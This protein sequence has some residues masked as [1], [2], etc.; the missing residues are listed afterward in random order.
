MSSI[1]YILDGNVQLMHG[2]GDTIPTPPE[3]ARNVR[4]ISTEEAESTVSGLPRNRRRNIDR[5]RDLQV[6][7]GISYDQ[8]SGKD[9]IQVSLKK[10]WD[11]IAILGIAVRAS[12]LVTQGETRPV[13]KYRGD[14]D[15]T[16]TLTPQEAIAFATTV[17]EHVEAQY[18]ASW[19]AKDGL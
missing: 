19:M 4:V 11:F 9:P 17:F 14:G 12:L 1:K 16:H 10:P 8:G 13:L 6:R 5:L 7:R 3:G 2:P 18:E 15:V